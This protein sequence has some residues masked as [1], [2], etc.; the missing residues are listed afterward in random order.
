MRKAIMADSYSFGIEEEYFLC[1]S[2]SRNTLRFMPKGFIERA[3]ALFTAEVMPEML[4]SQIEVATMP[5][6]DMKVAAAR[7]AEIRQ[8]LGEIGRGFGIGVLAAGTHPLAVWSKQRSTEAARYDRVMHELQMVGMRNVICGL[9][10]HVEL[11]DPSRRVNV[12][13]RVL[14]WLPLLFALSTSSPF[15]QGRRTGLMGYRLA[16]NHELP[17]S[18]IPDLFQDQADYD[19]YVDTLVA[20]RMIRDASYVWWLIRPSLKHPTLEL[21]VADSCTRV[22]HSISIAAL[23]RCLLRR[24]DRDPSIN[25]RMTGASRAIVCENLWRAQRYGIHASFVDEATRSACSAEDMLND[26]IA[27]VAPDAE[28]LGC[29]DEVAACR[30]ILAGGTSADEQLG[31]FA[32]AEARGSDPRRALDEVVDRLTTVTCGL[33]TPLEDRPHAA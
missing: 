4:Q 9:H 6:T 19:R 16:A 7:L 14:P 5:A 22:E 11:P 13:V 30:D 3:K 29:W 33:R 21:R 20:S 25:G 18:G 17:R 1:G 27:L 23:Y 28:A 10:V 12:M 32:A 15:W 2:E 26:A 8:G 24:L 31:V